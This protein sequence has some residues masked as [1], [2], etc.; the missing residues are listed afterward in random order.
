MVV[1][2]VSNIGGSCRTTCGVEHLA[3]SVTRRRTGHAAVAHGPKGVLTGNAIDCGSL[4]AGSQTVDR[5]VDGGVGMRTTGS[6]PNS[7]GALQRDR[8]GARNACAAAAGPHLPQTDTN[9]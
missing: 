4:P 8:H 3:P 5:I 7:I 1:R 6:D 2:F 9:P